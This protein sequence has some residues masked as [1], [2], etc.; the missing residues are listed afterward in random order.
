GGGK[1]PTAEVGCRAVWVVEQGGGADARALQGALGEMARDAK[2]AVRGQAALALARLGPAGEK[3]ALPVLRGMLKETDHLLRMQ[4]ARA[5]V[6][7][8]PAHVDEV[9][10]ALSDLST[11]KFTGARADAIGVLRQLGPAGEKVAL[12]ALLEMLNE[13]ASR[14]AALG[15][16]PGLDAE[17][18]KEAA[19]A[20]L[21]M[22]DDPQPYTREMAARAL[23]RLG[24]DAAGE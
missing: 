10:G 21:Q 6:R 16:L 12:P 18:L 9:I 15:L 1:A 14:S 8:D 20:L 5:L 3:L 2:P 11:H 22:L 23:G 17:A 13:P 4:A 7:I 19:P 24:E